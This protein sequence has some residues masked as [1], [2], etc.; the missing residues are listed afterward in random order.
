[1]PRLPIL[2]L[3]ILMAAPASA[4][5]IAPAAVRVIDGDTIAVGAARYRLVGFDAPELHGRSWCRAAEPLALAARERLREIVAGGRLDLHEITCA[6]SRRTTGTR[7]CNYG[8]RCG[9][10]RAAGRD[11]GE[12]LIAEGLAHPYRFDT[13]HRARA[14][15]WCSP[16]ERRLP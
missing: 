3:A 4:E 1:M 14:R 13:R 15:G 2:A 10:L 6:C 16:K 5:P 9:T 7:L 8:R 12:I 11:V